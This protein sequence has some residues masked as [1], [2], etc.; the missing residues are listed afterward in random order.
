MQSWGTQSRFTNRDTEMEPTKSGVIGL[1]CAALGRPRNASISDLSELKMGVRVDREGVLKK[2]YHTAQNVAKAGGGKP[3]ECEPS[4]RFY[5]ADACF[6]V[7]LEGKSILLEKIDAALEKPVWQVYLGRKSFVPGL[8]VRLKDGF[9]PEET[10]LKEALSHYPYLAGIVGSDNAPECLRLELEVFYGQGFR[11][12]NDQPLSFEIN[13][14]HY[15]LRHL[16]TDWVE[17]KSLPEFGKEE[18]CTFLF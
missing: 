7:A 9:R 15:N 17:L 6:L 16:I 12:K 8:P 13:N 3:K 11:V 5:L 4:E 10:G 18:Q 2:D 1:L 14:R